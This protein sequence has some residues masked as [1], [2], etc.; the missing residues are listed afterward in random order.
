MKNKEYQK[1]LDE[2]IQETVPHNDI[3]E[4]NN[5]PQAGKVYA[6]TGGTGSKCIANGNTW[7]ESEV[8]DG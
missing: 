6:L 1:E 5:I 8:K 4:A 3:A 2:A 7:K